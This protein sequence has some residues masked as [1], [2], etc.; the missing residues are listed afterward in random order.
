MRL[1]LRAPISIFGGK[2]DEKTHLQLSSRTWCSEG[3]PLI[4][5][6]KST[7]AD[8]VGIAS[9]P[10]Y[11]DPDHGTSTPPSSRDSTREYIRIGVL[12][13]YDLKFQGGRTVHDWYGSTCL[14]KDAPRNGGSARFSS[15]IEWKV[16]TAADGNVFATLLRRT[17]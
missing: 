5:I 16:D 2:G 4:G 13:H 12:S 11:A 14:E 3:L 10:D 17:I 1:R 15:L 7:P 6:T 9:P 8:D